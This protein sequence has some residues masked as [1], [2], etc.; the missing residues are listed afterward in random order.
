[1]AQGRE[2]PGFPGAE[3]GAGTATGISTAFT[4]ALANATK[5][6]ATTRI[7]MTRVSAFMLSS[8]SKHHAY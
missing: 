6:A 3:N 1:V 2:N 5:E 7:L 4:F 8:L